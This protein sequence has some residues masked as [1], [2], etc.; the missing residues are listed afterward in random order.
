M[1]ILFI[2][3][4]YPGEDSNA[5]VFVEQLV[6]SI[7]SMGHDCLVIAPNGA[8]PWRYYFVPRMAL[9]ERNGVQ[10]YRPRYFI[11][12][13]L[14]HF[15]DSYLHDWFRKRCVNKT[16]N[17]IRIKPDAIYCHFW[18]CAYESFDYSYKYDIPLFVASGES[19][20]NS[21]FE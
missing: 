1:K 15:G 9:D 16:L 19:N 5:F 14:L 7:S 3:P 10:I 8:M 13:L 21:G 12:P 2:S 4:N 11:V 20:I 6:K 18:S 17:S